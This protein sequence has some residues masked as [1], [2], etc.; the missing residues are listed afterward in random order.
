MP[1]LDSD[2]R[3]SGDPGSDR[4][5]NRAEQRSASLTLAAGGSLQAAAFL[6]S[7]A[8][9]IEAAH[10]GNH[11]IDAEELLSRAAVL[12]SREATRLAS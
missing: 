9:S 3:S 12:T 7:V 8:A 2:A 4:R 6:G 11:P 5:R 10:V 1:E